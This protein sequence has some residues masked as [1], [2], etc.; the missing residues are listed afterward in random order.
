M[1]IALWNSACPKKCFGPPPTAERNREPNGPIMEIFPDSRRLPLQIQVLACNP[2]AALYLVNVLSAQSKLGDL[3]ASPPASDFNFVREGSSARLFILDTHLLP[4]ELSKVIRNLS[5]YCPGSRFVAVL[6]D[7][8]YED[9]DILHMLYLGLD[10]LVKVSEDLEQELASAVNTVLDGAVWAPR[11]L[12]AE[13][14]RQTNWLRSDQFLARFSLTP[15]ESQVLQ[16]ALRRL[17]NKEIGEVLR[18]SERT[19]KFHISNIFDKLQVND[20]QSLPAALGAAAA[21][22]PSA[23]SVLAP[24]ALAV[25]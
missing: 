12:L 18:I 6:S 5:V 23:N 1:A 22:S 10:G 15:R 24:S 9:E 7:R 16:F 4:A 25:G 20:R 2:L 14:V 13:Y 8:S 3:L 19:V 17:S 21:G 11:R